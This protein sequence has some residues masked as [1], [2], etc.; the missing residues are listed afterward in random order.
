MHTGFWWEKQ[1]EKDHYE[2][3]DI[4]TRKILKWIIMKHDGMYGLGS[5]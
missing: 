3:P 1:N 4:D 5:R 2:D